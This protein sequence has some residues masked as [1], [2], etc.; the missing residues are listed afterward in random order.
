[1]IFYRIASKETPEAIRRFL[2]KES[3]RFPVLLDRTG[4]TERILGIWVHPTT[5]LINRQALVC[6]RSMG[7][8]DWTSLQATSI[9][10]QLLQKR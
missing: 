5:Y 2:E 8:F 3:L 9:I 10:D 7:A 6:Y 1:L 4:Q